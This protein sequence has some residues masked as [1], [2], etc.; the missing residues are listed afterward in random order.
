MASIPGFFKEDKRQ[1][2][3]WNKDSDKSNIKEK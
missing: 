1:R 3:Q 2:E